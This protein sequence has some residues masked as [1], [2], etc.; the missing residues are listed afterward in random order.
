MLVIDQQPAV[1]GLSRVCE[2]SWLGSWVVGVLNPMG[3][4]MGDDETGHAAEELMDDSSD[5]M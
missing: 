4:E 3:D 2:W 1:G 5:E